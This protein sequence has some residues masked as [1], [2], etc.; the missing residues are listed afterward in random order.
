MWKPIER[1]KGT[2][3]AGELIAEGGRV[4]REDG[5]VKKQGSGEREGGWDSESTVVRWFVLGLVSEFEW[6]IE[7]G[8]ETGEDIGAH[9]MQE[10]SINSK[11][12]DPSSYINHFLEAVDMRFC[13]LEFTED[14][15][16]RV[17]NF[18]AVVVN[19]C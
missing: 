14:A 15:L 11:I 6:K 2:S 4:Q 10:H 1:A 8:M 19:F 18:G 3:G 5:L 7:G 17:V 13:F 16:F 12:S 9:H